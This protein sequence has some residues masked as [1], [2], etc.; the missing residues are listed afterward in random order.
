MKHR[1]TQWSIP[2]LL[3]QTR[4]KNPLE[5]KGLIVYLFPQDVA[6]AYSIGHYSSSKRTGTT[7]TSNGWTIIGQK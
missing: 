1:Y 5:H 7:F 6:E 4:R 3:Y 2:R